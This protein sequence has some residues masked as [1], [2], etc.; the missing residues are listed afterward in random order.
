[1]SDFR[2]NSTILHEWVKAPKIILA[3]KLNWRIRGSRSHALRE[4]LQITPAGTSALLEWN[5]RAGKADD[6]TTYSASLLVDKVRVRGVDYHPIPRSY[7]YKETIPT[8]WHQDI[9][10]PATTETRRERLRSLRSQTC[11]TSLAKSPNCGIFNCRSF[12]PCCEHQN[13]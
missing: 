2:Y 1:V 11:M 9:Y 5:V 13:Q 12:L 6:P 8:G 3:A 4:I 10:D 7:F